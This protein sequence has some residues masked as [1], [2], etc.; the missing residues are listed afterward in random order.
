MHR[1]HDACVVIDTAFTIDTRF[2]RP[3]KPFKGISIKNMFPN[4]PT[5]P[6]KIFKFKGAT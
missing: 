6:L 1:M 2:E 5:T 4:C 3:W